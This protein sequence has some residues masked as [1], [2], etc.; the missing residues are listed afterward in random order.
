MAREEAF[1]TTHPR[2]SLFVMGTED[3]GYFDLLQQVIE[4]EQLGFDGADIRIT[5]SRLLF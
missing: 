2:I 4:A 1:T 5:V 3:A